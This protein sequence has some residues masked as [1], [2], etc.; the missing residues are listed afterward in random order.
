MNN[1]MLTA[2]EN[3][4]VSLLETIGVFLHGPA[5]DRMPPDTVSALAQ[6]YNSAK[7]LSTKFCTAPSIQNQ[8]YP[9][10]DR[11]IAQI[12]NMAD[13]YDLDFAMLTPIIDAQAEFK[14]AP[15][16]LPGE[17]FIPRNRC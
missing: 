9:M 12:V 10:I 7:Q 1:K 17:E 15:A 8:C 3:A 6:H 2:R 13:A 4:A 5:R 16:Y 14:E 11:L